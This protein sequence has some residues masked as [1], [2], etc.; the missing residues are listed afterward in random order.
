MSSVISFI[1]NPEKVTIIQSQKADQWFPGN[2]KQGKREID[3]DRASGTFWGDKMFY[4]F[5][6]VV[7]AFL[8]KFIKIHKNIHLK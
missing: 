2:G 4:I 5:I 7:V 1:G 8:N 6:M 3:W